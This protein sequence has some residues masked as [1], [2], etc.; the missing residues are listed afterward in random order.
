MIALA[1][2]LLGCAEPDQPT[3]V[4]LVSLDTLRADRLGAWG[5]PR[6]LTPIPASPNFLSQ[7][8]LL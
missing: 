8:P 7:T 4:I 2:P 3:G 6:G 1:L 5:N